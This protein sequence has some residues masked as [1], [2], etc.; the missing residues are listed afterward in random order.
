MMAPQNSIGPRET[1]PAI[2]ADTTLLLAASSFILPA[3][4][5]TDPR[6]AKAFDAAATAFCNGA[7]LLLPL[8][9]TS[10]EDIPIFLDLWRANGL[11]MVPHLELS[12]VGFAEVGAI[13]A[14][15]FAAFVEGMPYDAARW[16]QFQFT[17]ACLKNHLGR[18]SKWSI[19]RA[20][21]IA[22]S[23]LSAERLNGFKESILSLQKEHAFQEPADLE[24]LLMRRE[25][26]SFVH[27]C[28]AYAISVCVRGFSY[29]LSLGR[30]ESPPAY[31]HHWVRIPALKALPLA[32]GSASFE[33]NP[34]RWFP[35]GAVLEKVFDPGQPLAPREGHAV[36][37]VLSRIRERAADLR[38]VL[39]ELVDDAVPHHDARLSERE[40]LVVDTLAHA[41]VYL[42]Y[43][44]STR[45][46]A[47][48]QWLRSVVA[49]Q[50][51]L[52]R[53]PVELVTGNLQP[54]WARESEEGLRFRYRRDTFWEVF[55]DPGI[56]EALGR[57]TAR[58]PG[59]SKRQ[60]RD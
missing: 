56:R 42:R 58:G 3:S 22:D 2:A 29:A 37:E 19:L 6:A 26:R 8:P 35:W 11:E 32:G 38:D 46:E 33:P 57:M 60:T 13:V 17:T 48:A 44:N 24:D 40:A 7:K 14:G 43:A 31:R 53:V 28:A 1:L 59:S 36:K 51:P 30:R 47:L 54:R 34:P 15:Q 12:D 18:L 50:L 41:G 20:G 27:L 9:E 45:P 39:G 55:S 4:G 49:S 16:V 52:L 5:L 10:T 21:D 23:L 25:I